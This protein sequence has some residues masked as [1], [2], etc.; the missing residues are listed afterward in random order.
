MTGP[1]CL[2]SRGVRAED[3]RW[4]LGALL[5]HG[6]TLNFSSNI[7]EPLVGSDEKHNKLECYLKR[8][9]WPLCRSQGGRREASWPGPGWAG[10]GAEDRQSVSVSQRDMQTLLTGGL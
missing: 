8:S 6:K 7:R 9:F 4:I 3:K 1:E 5:G 2:Q 10:E